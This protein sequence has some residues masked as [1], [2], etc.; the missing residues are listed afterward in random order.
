MN[1]DPELRAALLAAFPPTP[2]SHETVHAADARWAGYDER[3]Q[4]SLLEGESWNELTPDVLE[5]HAGLLVHTGN[6]LYRAI[7]PAYLLLLAEGDYATILPFHVVSQLTCNQGSKLEG[8][9]FEE[10]V[11]S[12]SAEQRAVVRRALTAI[13]KQTLLHDVASTAIRSW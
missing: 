5:R 2:I 1:G 9:I 6:A 13:A 10:R 8:E 11:G 7:L 3:D 12:L 4:L